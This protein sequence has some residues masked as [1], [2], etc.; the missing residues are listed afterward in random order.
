MSNPW[1]NQPRVASAPQTAGGIKNKFE[2][3]AKPEPKPQIIR[4]KTT[5]V[6]V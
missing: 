1:K 6:E 3:L 5:Y 2:D 4:G